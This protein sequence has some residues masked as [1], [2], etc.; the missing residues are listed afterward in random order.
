MNDSHALI[1]VTIASAVLYGVI[2][3]LLGRIKLAHAVFANQYHAASENLGMVF[4][5]LGALLTPSLADLLIAKVGL[6][7]TLSVLAFVCLGLSLVAIFTSTDPAAGGYPKQDEAA[8]LE[9]VFGDPSVWLCGL[10]FLLYGPLEG[11]LGTWTTTYLTALHFRPR[12]A[13][14]LLSGLM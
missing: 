9:K 1:P 10:V 3:S 14:L 13:P 11:G 5:G 4:M 12:R 7:R 8:S 2:L 6:R